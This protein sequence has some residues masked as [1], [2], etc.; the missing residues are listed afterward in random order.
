MKIIA[1]EEHVLDPGMAK[2]SAPESARLCPGFSVAYAAD[3]GLP[4]CP[5]LEELT[6]LGAGRLAAM[7]SGGVSMQVL[8]A[9][10]AQQLP[11]DVAPGLVRAANDRMAAAVAEYPDRFAAFAAL[12][13]AAP[14]AAAAEL[15]RC[16]SEL[17]FV[18]TMIFG[19]TEEEFLDAERFEPL[20][21][22]AARLGTPVYLHPGLVPR[23]TAAANYER[24]LP[25]IAAAR[26]ETAAWGWHNETAVHFIHLVLSGV[27]DRYPE[28]QF[29]LGHWG[30][31]VPFYFER[32]NEALPTKATGLER[33]FEQYLRE[34]LYITPSGMWSQAQLQ[35]CLQMMGAE[36]I[37]FSVDYPFIGNEGATKFLADAQIDERVKHQIAHGNAERLLGLDA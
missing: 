24:G 1:L 5:S 29:I 31:L 22:A 19:R 17:G 25:P 13:T 33:T 23:D 37:M 26:F 16:V 3:S 7:D 12:P 18:G 32:L 14:Q 4:Y 2:A 11:A 35:F 15:E 10:N 9:L 6:D 8:S 30:E 36:R 21:A 20:L 27:L 34:N 28:L